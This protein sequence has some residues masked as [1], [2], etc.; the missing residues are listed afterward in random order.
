MTAPDTPM[1]MNVKKMLKLSSAIV[2]LKN[3]ACRSRR[4]STTSQ[5]ADTASPPM[6]M[7]ASARFL[8]RGVIR[9]AMRIT[10]AVS[11][12]ASTGPSLFRSGIIS[13]APSRC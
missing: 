8:S 7:P 4:I 6:A 5:T 10:P 13:P 9:S 3:D 12:T 11:I 2:S 1:N